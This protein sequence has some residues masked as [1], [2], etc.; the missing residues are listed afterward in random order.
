MALLVIIVTFHYDLLKSTCLARNVMHLQDIIRIFL[1]HAK[2]QYTIILGIEGI[3]I[4][5]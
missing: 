3:L 1:E 2:K 5:Y 4:R